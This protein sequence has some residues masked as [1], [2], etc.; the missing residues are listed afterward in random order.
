MASLDGPLQP[1]GTIGDISFYRVKQKVRIR[2]KRGKIA[3]YATNR[4]YEASRE[5]NRAFA[6]T[7]KLA[8]KVKTSFEKE[9]K[10]CSEGSYSS[11]LLKMFRILGYQDTGARRGDRNPLNGNLSLLNGFQFNIEKH[12]Q[13]VFKG[14]YKAYIDSR[15]GTFRVDVAAFNPLLDIKAPEGAKYFQILSKCCDLQNNTRFSSATSKLISVENAGVDQFTL[16]GQINM[17]EN[18]TAVVVFAVVFYTVDKGGSPKILYRNSMEIA[19]ICRPASITN[20]DAESTTSSSYPVIP[21]R[22]KNRH[23]DPFSAESLNPELFTETREEVGPRRFW[24]EIRAIRG[25]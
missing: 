15:E 21:T 5:S 8:S 16:E 7:S 1:T 14:E 17:D 13:E 2:R 23:P 18:A 12:V 19:A 3:N 20:G 11:R 6:R 22:F 4:R 24:E 10:W 9:L 25:R